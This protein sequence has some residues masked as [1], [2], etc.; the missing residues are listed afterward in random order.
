MTITGIDYDKC[1]ACEACVSE[2][3]AVLF[4]VE[5]SGGKILYEDPKRWCINCGHCIA[6]C[7]EDAILYEN[8]KDDPI[9]FPEVPHPEKLVSYDALYKVFRA[10]RSI[11]QYKSDP[12]PVNLLKKVFEAM[13]Y[14]PSGSNMRSWKFRVVSDPAKLAE[15]S[16]TIQGAILENPTLSMAY[17]EKLPERVAMGRDP[18]FLGAPHVVF[19]YSPMDMDIEGN[20]TGIIFTYGMLAAQALGIGS[21]WIGLAQIPLAKNRK[22]QK[23]VGIRGKCWG[24][25]TLGFPDVEYHRCP[26][27]TPLDVKGL[28]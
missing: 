26:P 10:K 16:K 21:C 15:L 20:N 19:L 24:V 4:H 27:R 6:V 23:I 1:V 17:G 12:V 25:M 5:G 13:Q 28:E 9:S 11:R 22:L 18:I 3:P 7:P 14:A 2:C 8:F